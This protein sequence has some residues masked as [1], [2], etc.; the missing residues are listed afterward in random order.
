MN[1][2]Q[3]SNKTIYLILIGLL[4][5]T[6]VIVGY[7]LVNKNNI[8]TELEKANTTVNTQY[9]ELQIQYNQTI[10]ELNDVKGINAQMDS[11]IA[12]RE[13]E[14]IDK[15]SQIETLLKKGNLSQAEISKAKT[16]IAE[17]KNE[18][19][20][21]MD[22]LAALKEENQGLKTQNTTLSTNLE[23]EIKAKEE[24]SAA[25]GKLEE[26][27]KYL[28]SKYDLGSLLQTNNLLAVG[29]RVKDSGK[30]VETN[31][32]KKMQKLRICYETGVNNIIDKGNV[33]HLIRI[34]APNGVTITNNESGTFKGTDGTE[35]KYSKKITFEY[36]NLNSKKCIYW[37]GNNYTPGVHVVE[38]YQ[39]SHK[40]GTTKFELN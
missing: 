10:S 16:L 31:K 9:N 32:I 17:L 28:N 25:K 5:L 3:K 7:F 29:V 6:N 30:E 38:I 14:L 20:K 34:L 37:E 8:N 35:V 1:E 22:E 12:L 15:K 21:V 26:T 39:G 24:L 36:N 23:N 11:V 27:N 13:S 4:L 33:D 40:I 19:K 2:N 18:N